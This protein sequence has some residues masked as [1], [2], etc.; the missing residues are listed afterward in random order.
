LEKRDTAESRGSALRLRVEAGF[1]AWG[2]LVV[3]H[4]R[5]VVMLALLVTVGLGS[6]IPQLRVDNSPESFLHPDDPAREVYDEF[7]RRFDRDDRTVIGLR[8]PVV[9]DSGFLRALAA[10]HRDLEAAVPYVE[11]VTSLVNARSTYGR[12]DELV[13]EDLLE[14][15]PQTPA[16][17]A[18]LRER[19]FDT[20]LY[21]NSLISRD[22]RL[23]TLILKPNTYSSLVDDSGLGGFDE[24]SGAEPV[25]LT[26]AEEIEMV[27]ALRQ[28]LDRHRDAGFEIFAVGGPLMNVTLNQT[29]NRDA[30]L[31]VLVTMGVMSLI[32][33]L[34]FRRASGVLLPMIVVVCALVGTLGIMV[35]LDIPMS[36]VLQILPAFL[37]A[38]GIC[39]SLHLMVIVYQQMSEGEPKNDAIAYA[40]G[41]SALPC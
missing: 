38:V 19:I 6:L 37:L 22:G 20:P 21:V 16:D 12:G 33:L 32:L 9:F 40:L 3:R 23:V 36:T 17:M 41:H 34:L 24:G 35:L 25:Y 2:H 10:L 7:R 1:E 30:R 11:E 28:L 13:V 29:M 31:F 5:V 4:R 15:W 39:D 26:D 8:P 18:R 27:R 14:Q